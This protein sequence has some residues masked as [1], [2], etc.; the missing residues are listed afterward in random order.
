[1]GQALYRKYRSKTLTD[2]IGQDHITKTLK[3][4]VDS[5]RISHAYL[6][7][8]PRGVGKTSVAR[9]LAHA[10]NGL[11]YNDDKQY[12]D[13]I[14]ID[15]AS[16]GRIEEIR[17][18]RDKVYIAP[19]ETKYKV[20][21]ID[22]VHMITIN[23]FN[24]LLKTLEEPPEHVVFI[25]ATTE[26]H[27]LPPTI[28][29]R[30]QRFQFKPIDTS[31]AVK[32]LSYIA[33]QEG[34]AIDQEALE[35]I[36][37]HGQGSFR[38]SISLL[39]Q[40]ANYSNPITTEA[41]NT[42]LGN[43]PA[44]QLDELIKNLAASNRQGVAS[45]LNGLYEQSYAA[46]MIAKRLAER[47]RR[48][49]IADSTII[50]TEQL[51]VLLADLIEVPA[52]EDPNS[53][54]LIALLKTMPAQSL[55]LQAVEKL[56]DQEPITQTKPARQSEPIKLKPDSSPNKVTIKS[57]T[58]SNKPAQAIKKTETINHVDD[59]IWHQV[60]DTL[61]V[62]H[63]TLY[64]IV[65]MAKLDSSDPRVIRLQFAYQFHKQRVND[66]KNREVILKAVEQITKT[67]FALEC[68]ID[69]DSL[70]KVTPDAPPKEPNL[71]AI[72]NIF[73]GGEMLNP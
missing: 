34:I 13:I 18:L 65:R 67:S 16:N 51:L 44:V 30:T 14:E 66:A 6:F 38:D 37:E 29:S 36:A 64:G 24:A 7:T 60:L 63:N 70:T 52:S 12:V 45:D 1:M 35:L 28:V 4:A 41:I 55:N 69:K 22:E 27:K 62:K 3:Q 58:P 43:P 71:S 46:P 49:L 42:L 2:I 59:L 10:I 31:V 26:A 11:T 32:H 20:Y 23:A 33:K 48:Y 54:L 47:F 5:G 39:D 15:G 57:K 21:I 9:I 19:T 56:H 68:V 53:S 50:P 25:L 8:G 72:N 61:K 40:A 73:G 17:E